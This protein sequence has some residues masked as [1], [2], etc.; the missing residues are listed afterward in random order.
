MDF[1]LGLSAGNKPM[2]LGKDI[3]VEGYTESVDPDLS[4]DLE[5]EEGKVVKRRGGGCQL[6]CPRG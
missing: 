2:R 3:V 1:A 6:H 4:P 5:R